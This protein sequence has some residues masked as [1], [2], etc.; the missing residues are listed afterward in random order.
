[1]ASTGNAI[2]AYRDLI[3]AG[4]SPGAAVGVV[5]NLIA[6][7]GVNP[8]SVQAGGGPG[9]GIAQWS[10]GAR[11]ATLQ[12]W[13]AAHSMDPMTLDTQLAFLIYEARSTGVWGQLLGTSDPQQASKIFMTQYE[14]PADQSAANAAY[15]ASLGQAA[16]A[17]A[18]TTGGA[19]PVSDV[20]NAAT[21]TASAGSG[22]AVGWP[23]ITI[24]GV[25]PGVG[26][27]SVGSFCLI[28]QRQAQ[29]ILGGLLLT[30]GAVVGA[31]GLVVLAAYGFKASGAAGAV[32]GAATAVSRFV[33]K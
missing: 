8:A 10:V 11:W 23:G 14:R 33:P 21:A 13:A 28:S 4:L 1:M 9:R 17:G 22:C 18:S 32:A 6:E 5:G 24:P 15:R 19:A 12:S 20:V 30:A 25:V 2:T 3:A 31:V 7:S 27:T 16:V 26:G 29:V